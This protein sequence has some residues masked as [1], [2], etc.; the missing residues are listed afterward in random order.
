MDGLAISVGARPNRAY[1]SVICSLRPS[2]FPSWP[3]GSY[4]TTDRDA[5]VVISQG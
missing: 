1:C 4:V 5:R 2:S 3:Q